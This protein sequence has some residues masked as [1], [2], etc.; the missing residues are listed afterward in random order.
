MEAR[1]RIP[2]MDET[3]MT[4][5]DE[6]RTERE[7]GLS[8]NEDVSP[9]EPAAEGTGPTGPVTWPQLPPPPGGESPWWVQ[10][11]SQPTA[12]GEGLPAAASSPPPRRGRA[13]IAALVAALVLLSGG[14]GI[15]WVL[16][17]GGG[18]AATGTEAPLKTVP[19]AGSSNGQTARQLSQQAIANLVDPA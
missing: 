11:G 12:W 1:C 6:E 13:W 9:A 19:P 15:G 10:Q 8:A 2:A 16:S 14:I 17:K 5:E 3:P 4:P 18:T 7:G